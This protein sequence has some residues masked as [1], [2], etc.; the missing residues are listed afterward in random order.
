MNRSAVWP[1]ML[2]LA[3]AP[4]LVVVYELEV[5]F[6]KSRTLEMLMSLSCWREMIVTLR[7]TSTML[8]AVPNTEVNGRAVGR[9]CFSMGTSLTWNFSIVTTSPPGAAGVDWAPAAGASRARQAVAWTARRGERVGRCT[10][11]V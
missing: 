3:G 2:G 4:K 7:G 6:E 8:S 11:S 5:S 9:I 1:R 10:S